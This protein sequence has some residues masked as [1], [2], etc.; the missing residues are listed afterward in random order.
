MK[1]VKVSNWYFFF[2]EGA[3]LLYGDKGRKCSRAQ[4]HWQG[5]RLFFC[6]CEYEN[7][8]KHTRASSAARAVTTA[9]TP[10]SA[11]TFHVL[12][13][14]S[15]G[16]PTDKTPTPHRSRRG[17]QTRC[18]SV[19]SSTRSL[20]CRTWEENPSCSYSIRARSATELTANVNFGRHRPRSP[21]STVSV[22][23]PSFKEIHLTP[24]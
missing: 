21:F 12:S 10:S 5:A 18:T 8:P 15:L 24:P 9:E 2:L 23:K 6:L 14:F 16:G 4:T 11:K 22:A 20:P 17:M 7:I 3:A 1:K 19:R 13:P